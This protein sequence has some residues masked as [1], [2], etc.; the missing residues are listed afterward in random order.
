MTVQLSRRQIMMSLAGLGL[1]LAA[2]AA[3]AAPTVA[4]GSNPPVEPTPLR[5]ALVLPSRESGFYKAVL[6][7]A[8][9]AATQAGA[10]DIL[11]A[12]PDRGTAKEQIALVK[13][14]V[15]Q[16]VDAIAIMPVD[17]AALARA[18]RQAMAAGIAVVSFDQ[19]L[20]VNAR[21]AHLNATSPGSKAQVFMDMLADDVRDGGDIAILAGDR[22]GEDGQ[23]L[24]SA[25]LK[26]WLK[27]A[28]GKFKAVETSFGNVD[29]PTAYANTEKL[30]AAHPNLRGILVFDTDALV[31]VAQCIQDKKLAGKVF[32]TGF[33]RPSRLVT[34]MVAPIDGAASL[35][36]FAAINPVDLGYGATEIAVGLVRKRA[37]AAKPDVIAAGRLGTITLGKDSVGVL[38]PFVVDEKNF[39]TMADT[40]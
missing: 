9:D 3:L 26:Q 12:A 35:E 39:E 24:V 5:L 14:F 15:K 25:T 22:M 23:P 21:H 38:P 29:Q 7:G 19:E 8:Q 20:P 33:G 32:V 36:C 13:D 28:Y 34:A 6:D 37:T 40:Y 16:K 2:P 17:G 11:I 10:V 30:L 18:C 31:S 1:A 4:P 27:P